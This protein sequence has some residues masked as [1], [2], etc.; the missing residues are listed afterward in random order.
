MA[1]QPPQPT[2]RFEQ[3]YARAGRRVGDR[4]L[5]RLIAAE[6]LRPRL[7][8]AKVLAYVVATAVHLLAAGLLVGGLLL[9]VL[10]FP[11]V[12]ALVGGSLMVATA[13]LLRPRLGK[14][15]VEGVLSRDQ[16]PELHT[17]VDSVARA[18]EVGP[19]HVIIAD[20]SYNASWSVVGLRRTRVLTVGLPLLCALD[21]QERVALV[22]HELAHARNGDAARGLYVGSA[23]SGLAELGALLSPGR[24]SGSVL[25]W[26][27]NLPLYLVSRPV[28]GLFLLEVHLLLGDS[29]RAEYQA[30]ALAARAAGT[31]AVVSLHEKLLL[32]PTLAALVQRATTASGVL[33]DV[34]SE[35]E[36]TVA[37]VPERERE[38]RRRIARLEDA[39]L[40]AT[41]PPT[42]QR[43]ELLE[44]RPPQEPLVRADP[45]TARRVDAELVPLRA[46]FQRRLADEHRD[47]LYY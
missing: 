29:R 32:E 19:P 42:A 17:L 46:G 18:L 6:D 12:A 14:A 10:A 4:V 24:D 7:T 21:P 31:S 26:L 1:P 25:D 44:A 22:A 35:F 45:E 47:R 39:R 13:V 40:G 33:F 16:A 9:A 8:A 28:L 43:I 34:L 3:L 5:R 41:H 36:A 30:D 20:H 38:R 15:P 23:A 11:N 27:V 2:G 37:R